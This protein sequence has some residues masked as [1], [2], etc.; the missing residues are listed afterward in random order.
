MEV[1]RLRELVDVNYSTGDIFWKARSD[2][3]FEG[4]KNSAGSRKRFNTIFAG[5]PALNHKSKGYFKGRIENVE[6]KA[7]RVVWAHFHGVWPSGLIDHI[8]RVRHDNRIHNLRDATHSQNTLNRHLSSDAPFI[9]HTSMPWSGQ[10]TID[11]VVYR[12]SPQAT[13][14]DAIQAWKDAEK[15]MIPREHWVYRTE[16]M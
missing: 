9:Y 16:D 15:E 1:R 11:G 2:A 13:K 8:N 10:R 7:H 14:E 6:L 3:D 5:K 4:S 12:I